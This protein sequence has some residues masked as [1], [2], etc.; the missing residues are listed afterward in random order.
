[1]TAHSAPYTT[2]DRKAPPKAFREV[3]WLERLPAPD[4]V[5]GFQVSPAGGDSSRAGRLLIA[6]FT[7]SWPRP[8]LDALCLLAVAGAAAGIAKFLFFAFLAI[9]L[10]V[11]I[12]GIA[13]GRKVSS[14][15]RRKD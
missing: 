4:E 6:L 11:L 15:L 7:T 2:D 10:I 3:R 5:A 14:T 1:M 12:L 8:A 9:F 13:A